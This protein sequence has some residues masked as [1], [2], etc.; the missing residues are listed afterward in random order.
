MMCVYVPFSLQELTVLH[1][2]CSRGNLSAVRELVAQYSAADCDS[3]DILGDTPL[4]KACRHGN[5]ETVK[6]L[7]DKGATINVGNNESVTPLHA[8]C[9][10]GHID[11][12]KELLKPGR[13]DVKLMFAARDH[14]GNTP[15]HCAVKAGVFE[16]VEVLL[17]LGADPNVKNTDGI[18]PTHVAAARGYADI[19][20]VLLKYKNEVK[21]ARDGA[22]RTPL[23]HAAIHNQV[24]IIT[25]LLQK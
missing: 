10:E 6:I 8:A 3:T 20:K 4:H 23:H 21:D 15:I 9:K 11:V 14:T 24:S 2:A 12:V 19:A 25:N 16:I 7:L 13:G 18:H 22:R 1:M 17:S 5:P